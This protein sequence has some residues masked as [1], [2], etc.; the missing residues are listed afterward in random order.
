[1]GFYNNPS[2][3]TSSLSCRV[4]IACHWLKFKPRFV[5]D[6]FCGQVAIKLQNCDE[7]LAF[8]NGQCLKCALC[9]L[10]LS[11][12]HLFFS[13]FQ[14]TSTSRITGV[15]LKAEREK[16]L[17]TFQCCSCGNTKTHWIPIRAECMW[18]RLHKE[19]K[20]CHSSQVSNCKRKIIYLSRSMSL[21]LWTK[22]VGLG[23]LL[24]TP[25]PK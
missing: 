9:M 1:M 2:H 7:V 25:P 18:V 16:K 17:A 4:T 11:C 10:I 13:N 5:K 22:G 23:L 21:W 15:S 6:Q 3:P 8:S 12:T 14:H 19:S 24:P 20:L